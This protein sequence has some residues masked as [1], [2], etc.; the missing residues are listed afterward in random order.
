MSLHD[1]FFGPLNKNFCVIFY[2]FTVFSFIF[3][4]LAVVGGIAVLVKKPKLLDLKNSVASV[5]ALFNLLLV[6]FIYRLIHTMCI[7]SL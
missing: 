4:C 3:I 2:I 1:M 5:L 7:K 6:Y